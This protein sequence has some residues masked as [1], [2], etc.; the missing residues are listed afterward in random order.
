MIIRPILRYLGWNTSDPCQVRQE[1]SIG[2]KKVDYALIHDKSLRVFIEV[3]NFNEDLKPGHEEQLIDYCYLRKVNKGILTNGRQWIFYNFN[4]DKSEYIPTKEKIHDITVS[5][6]H[7][8]H[9]KEIMINH[10]SKDSL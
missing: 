7:K 2:R 8:K 6:R 1:F 4:F 3:K 10:I 5:K 9:L